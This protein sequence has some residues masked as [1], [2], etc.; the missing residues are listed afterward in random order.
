[1]W[2]P[3][4]CCLLCKRWFCSFFSWS[5][6]RG[7]AVIVALLHE[8]CFVTGEQ[9]VTG[10]RFGNMYIVWLL[11]NSLVTVERF[12]HEWRVLSRKIWSQMNGL[13]TYEGFVHGSMVWL[14][15]NCLNR[16][17]RG[18]CSSTCFRI[19]A[20]DTCYCSSSF[21]F[22]DLFL[23]LWTDEE[24]MAKSKIYSA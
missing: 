2:F 9:M 18:A 5:C 1:M 21:V 22:G 20:T 23:I 24:Y 13:I 7:L 15:M 6:W 19:M 16:W 3:C 12:G 8:R 4:I 11:V 14:R 17:T 10:V